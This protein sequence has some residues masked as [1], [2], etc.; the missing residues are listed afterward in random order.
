MSDS[1]N[2]TPP[3]SGA[4]ATPVTCPTAP[5]PVV[6]ALLDVVE[7]TFS[8]NHVVEKD[9]LGNFPSPEWREGRAATDNS[10]VCYTRNTSVELTAKFRVTRQPT[11]TESV[12]V[13]GQGTFVSAAL[14]WTGTVSVSP[15]DQEVTASGMTSNNPLPNQVA[16]FDL[17][18]ITWEA[19]PAGTG[20]TSAGDS[21]HLM[22]VVLADPSGTPAYWTLLDISC[23]AAHGA[24]TEAGVVTNAYTPLESRSIS[25]KRD[26]H[27][28]TYWNPDTTNCTNTQMLLA[29]A[30]G[31]GQ[32]GSWAEFLVDM[33]KCHG[34]TTTRKV[35][36]YRVLP[37]GS[38][39]FL[40]KNWSFVGSGSQPPPWT[41]L[42][43]TECVEL[44]G[45]PGQTNPD[46]PPAFYNHFI[47]QHGGTY[48]DPS[49]GAAS[50]TSQSAWENGSI[51]GLFNGS[52]A[53][54]EKSAH[55]ATDLLTFT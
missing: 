7:I 30:D 19:N 1:R 5:C 2:P 14:E 45:A 33:Y 34:I 43:G 18:R 47:V 50:V 24:T 54:Y 20:W 42:L 6:H 35:M 13:R 38:E 12:Q 44:P 55:Q 36:I 22:Y 27:A 46:P 26:G 8:G 40:V 53:G 21:D 28:L 39:G 51:D 3:G 4:G 49:Y 41:H 37:L 29:R 9:T 11:A 32:C 17:A 48:Y 25:R 10:P 15:G 31:S 23:R 52:R 16:C